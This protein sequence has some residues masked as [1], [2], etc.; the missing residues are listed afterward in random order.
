MC[1]GEDELAVMICS[2]HDGQLFIEAIEPLVIPSQIDHTCL[3]INCTE[4]KKPSWKSHETLLT[5]IFET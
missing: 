3:T 4:F 2:G 1:F 5:T